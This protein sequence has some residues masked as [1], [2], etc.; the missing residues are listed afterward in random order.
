MPLQETMPIFVIGMNGSGTTMLADS[1]G[2]HP[3][4]YMFPCET[5]SIPTFVQRSSQPGAR[6]DLAARRRLT[7][8][9]AESPFNTR[10]LSLLARHFCG[11]CF[12][13]II[14]DG[15][16]AARSFHRR[17]PP[18]PMRK[19]GRW[20]QVIRLGASRALTL[21]RRV[22][23]SFAAKPHVGSRS[24]DAL[25]LLRFSTALHQH[26]TSLFHAPPSGWA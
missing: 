10:R 17:W 21:A 26:A 3:S 2:H 13:H 25:L 6:Y 12:V 14:R 9:D 1:L 11:A 15:R 22:T 23:C 18:E 19:I 16:D 20:K 5:K 7:D 24:A 4:R 8:L